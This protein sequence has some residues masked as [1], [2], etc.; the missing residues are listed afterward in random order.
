MPKTTRAY[1]EDGRHVDVPDSDVRTWQGDVRNGR[2]TDSLAT[3]YTEDADDDVEIQGSADDSNRCDHDELSHRI[4]NESQT[5][6]GVAKDKPLRM[7]RVCHRRACILDAMA[8]VERGTGEPA[9]WAAPH[10]GYSFDVPKDIPA[11][12]PAAPATP[13]AAPAAVTPD[14]AASQG[15]RLSALMSDHDRG[16]QYALVQCVG[17]GFTC[18]QETRIEQSKNLS[19]AEVA[20]RLHERGWSVKPTLCPKHNITQGQVPLPVPEMA[21]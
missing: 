5:G 13:A 1:L 11:P 16:A 4:T 12:Q 10:Q 14:T 18:S 15:S 9:A 17:A 20:A 2:T 21:P 19:D 7:A 3:W 8:W 6:P